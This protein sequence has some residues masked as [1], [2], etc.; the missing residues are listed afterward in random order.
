[1]AIIADGE[2]VD[3]LFAVYS[4]GVSI[5]TLS[6]RWES[7]EGVDILFAVYSGG[8]SIASL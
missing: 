4:G 1:M 3:S 8:V 7:R 5:D 2:G 6:S